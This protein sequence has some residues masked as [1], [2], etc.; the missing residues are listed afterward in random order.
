M[1][2]RDA[3]NLGD[4]VEF[5]EVGVQLDDLPVTGCQGLNVQHVGWGWVEVEVERNLERGVW[6]GDSVTA[7]SRG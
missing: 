2:G 3:A 4:E 7:C 6:M 5:E 1:G